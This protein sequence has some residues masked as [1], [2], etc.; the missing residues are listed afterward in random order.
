[1][2][3]EGQGSFLSF[4]LSHLLQELIIANF[5]SRVLIVMGN[6][7]SMAMTVQNRPQIE[8]GGAATVQIGFYCT[9]FFFIESSHIF[10]QRKLRRC[11]F[12]QF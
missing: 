5:I 10:K 4:R 2:I 6:V 9:L 12:M 1:M 8:V 3:T 7:V 11:N